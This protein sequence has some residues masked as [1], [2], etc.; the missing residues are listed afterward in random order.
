MS[1]IRNFKKHVRYACGD[2]AAETLVASHYI[3]GFSTEDAHRIIGLIAQLQEDT[4]SKCKFFFD[5]ARRD[6]ANDAEYR[7][8]RNQYFCTAFAM[9][10]TNFETGLE[11]I[12]KEMNKALPTEAKEANKKA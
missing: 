3:N 2:L 10:R 4:L 8:A 9:L 6:F 7:K 5:R 12:V 1:S 11:A